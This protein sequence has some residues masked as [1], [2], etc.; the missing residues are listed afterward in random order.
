MSLLTVW[1][2]L[3]FLRQETLAWFLVEDEASWYFFFQDLRGPQ[4]STR[5]LFR[6]FNK[7]L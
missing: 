5:P 2:L 3:Y 6:L 7:V 1:N 4:N